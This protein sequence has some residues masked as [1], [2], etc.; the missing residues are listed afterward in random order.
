MAAAAAAITLSGCSDFLEKDSRSNVSGADFYATEAGFESLANAA[1]SS[2]RNLYSDPMWLTEGGA[3]LFGTGRAS[4]MPCA[5]YGMS[6]STAD[7]TV[8]TFYTESYKAISLANEVIFWAGSQESRA[9]AAA[10]ARGLKA[11]YYLNLA[12]QFGAV[13][14]LKERVGGVLDGV[15]KSPKADVLKYVISELE[16]IAAGSALAESSNDGSFN[17]K[18]AY[19]FMAKANLELGY[20]TG[21][22]SYFT[23]AQNAAVKAG[24]GNELTTPFATLFSNAGEGNS[25]VLF[26]VGYS[27]ETS[28]DNVSGNQQQASYGTYLNGAEAGHK[29]CN[30]LLAP[31][32]WM[33]EVFNQNTADANLDERYDATFMTELRES[34]WDFY[35]DKKDV[36][37]VTY[38]YCPSWRLADTA[39]WRAEL[40][41]RAN[42]VIIPMT[43]TGQ[44]YNG[45]VTAY[46]AKMR[47]DVY[48]IACFR[49]FDDVENGKATFSTTSSMRDVYLARLGETNLVAAEAALKLGNTADAAKYVN[50]VRARAKAPAATAAEMTIDYIL[51]ERARELAGEGFRWTDLVRTGKL[52]EYT[53]AHNY[54]INAADIQPKHSVRPIP[55]AAIELNPALEQNELWK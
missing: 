24:A 13:P 36:S 30:S 10:Q 32:V 44:N 41:S 11:F 22:N 42:A 51:N 8:T 27:L 5:L 25:E 3:D 17:K 33:H 9:A 29:Y 45:K 40:P 7:E 23:A 49:K 31:V 38:Y 16:A 2:L 46:S 48:G 6:Y 55:L 21:D 12:Q 39:A 52:A 26:Y 15:A 20:T 19:H 53:V 28:E 43:E 37:E 1:Y 54:D 50:V 35:T 14:I 18:A 34:Y 47:E 4:S